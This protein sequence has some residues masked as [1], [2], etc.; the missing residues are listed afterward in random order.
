MQ[1]GCPGQILHARLAVTLGHKGIH[2]AAQHFLAI[3]F[4]VSHKMI[5]HCDA[6]SLLQ[7]EYLF[8]KGL[9]DH[10]TIFI[11]NEHSNRGSAPQALNKANASD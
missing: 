8:K 2:G 6:P 10:S 11:L 4:G 7:F 1:A 3:E 9:N 5:S